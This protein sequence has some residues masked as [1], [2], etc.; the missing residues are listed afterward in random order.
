MSGIIGWICLTLAISV[1]Q[2]A[3]L[4]WQNELNK[5]QEKNV[6][7]PNDNLWWIS[8][9]GCLWSYR[10]QLHQTRWGP[11]LV[12]ISRS[13][14]ICC[15]RRSIGETWETVTTRL[16]KRGLWSFLVFSRVEKWSCGSRSIRETWDNFL[17]YDATSCSSSWRTSSRR[18]CAFRKVRK[19]DSWWIGE[20][21]VGESPRTGLFRE[22]RHGQWRS[23]ICEQSQRPSAKQTEK[24]VERCRVSWSAFNNMENVH[25]CHDKCGDIHGKEFLNYSQFHHEF[26]RSHFE[27]I[28][29]KYSIGLMIVGNLVWQQEDVREG[30]ISIALIILEESCTSE[31]FRDTLG[32]ISLTL[33][34]RT[35]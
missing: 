19:D 34:H 21:W 27:I 30:D 3:P 35:M 26:W 6:S 33:C 12:W 16:F 32:I 7:Q 18:R 25:G 24:N 9:R 5:D 2:L 20:T 4:Q 10:L 8:V 15:R 13:W 1:L 23:R 31:L 17:G 28:L 29:H 14:T 22:F 11:D